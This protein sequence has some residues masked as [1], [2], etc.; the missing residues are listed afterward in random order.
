MKIFFLLKIILFLTV[1][2][3]L[4]KIVG[5]VLY[6]NRPV[7]YELFISSKLEFFKDKKVIDI[8]VIGDSH[9]ADSFDPRTIESNIGFKTFNL[10]IYHSSPFENYYVTKAAL[11]KL[12]TKPSVIILGTN[13]IM[14]ERKMS[15]GRYS[16]LILPTLNYLELV[17]NS[18][19]GFD[20]SFFLSFIQEKYLFKSLLNNLR[21]KAYQPTRKIED[22]YNGHLKFFNQIPGTQW[23][24]FVIQK[25]SYLDKD[26]VE[27]FKKTI[28]LALANNINVIIAHPPIWNKNL[29]AL[30][31]TDSYRDFKNT[32]NSLSKKYE[33]KIYYDY[34][35]NNNI[36]NDTLTFQKGDYLNPKH[37]NYNGS[38]KFTNNFCDFWNNE[39]IIVPSTQITQ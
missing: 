2:L 31:N 1:F 33:L 26:Q 38:L 23:S 19:E 20:A 3:I 5:Y 4:D 37:L 13:P 39:E 36:L 24:D 21:G 28:E 8:L 7:D 35:N 17:S 22:V 18:N 27:Y 11:E 29:R 15:K 10:G 14:F 9:I 34:L 32:I 16:P 25:K 30:T 12:E 6:K